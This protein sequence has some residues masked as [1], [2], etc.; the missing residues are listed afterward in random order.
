MVQRKSHRFDQGAGKVNLRGKGINGFSDLKKWQE[1]IISDNTEAERHEEK[2]QKVLDN[3]KNGVDD[4]QI[5]PKTFKIVEDSVMN[6]VIGRLGN[7]LAEHQ[8]QKL[9]NPNF[10]SANE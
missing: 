8:T 1:K 3:L 2:F 6:S 5:D 10:Q 4:N 7:H 9:S